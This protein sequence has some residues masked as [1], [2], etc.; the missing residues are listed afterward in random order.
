MH[1]TSYGVVIPYRYSSCG[2]D[3]VRHQSKTHC[4]GPTSHERLTG[5]LSHDLMSVPE[6]AATSASRPLSPQVEV[7]PPAPS[8][9]DQG[10]LQ[11]SVEFSPCA[12]PE[13]QVGV[14]R[15][16]CS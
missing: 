1:D 13:Y 10:R 15:V 6:A 14:A 4:T 5:N 3:L 12:S 7:G 9:P 16:A 2:I 8:A 11:V